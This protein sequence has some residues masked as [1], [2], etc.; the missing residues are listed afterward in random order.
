MNFFISL[1]FV[2]RQ[3]RLLRRE[4]LERLRAGL[5]QTLN[6]IGHFALAA[7]RV[8]AKSFT[9]TSCFSAKI[10]SAIPPYAAY[11]LAAPVGW[12]L[13]SHTKTARL[14]P[15]HEQ[16][17]TTPAEP[18]IWKDKTHDFCNSCSNKQPACPKQRH[19]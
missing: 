4:A 6:L 18:Q 15:E 10:T 13:K 14:A 8:C 5:D 12:R 7:K 11:V 19:H 2:F 1:D 17:G 3:H 9:W 16:C